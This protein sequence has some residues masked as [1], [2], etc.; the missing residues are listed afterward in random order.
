MMLGKNI[1][2]DIKCIF[3]N[4]LSNYKNEKLGFYCKNYKVCYWS[5][6]FIKQV[7]YKD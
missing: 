2:D 6:C 7:N 5:K 1:S 4:K 3:L